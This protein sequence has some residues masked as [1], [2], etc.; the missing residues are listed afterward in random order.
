[1]PKGKVYEKTNAFTTHSVQGETFYNKIFIDIEIIY[2]N[3][4]RLLYT[5]ISRAK[6]LD[7]IYIVNNVKSVKKLI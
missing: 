5:A 1:M 4:L 2:S 3:N 6:K 7:Q